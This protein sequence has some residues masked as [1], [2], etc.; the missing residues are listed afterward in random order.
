[1]KFNK[2]NS[3]VTNSIYN[4][5]TSIGG[6]FITV[7]M[8]F[9]VRTVFIHT[10]GRS[11]LGIN[12]LFSNILSMLSLTELGLG[13]A[14]LFKLYDPIAKRDEHRIALLMKFYKTAYRVIGIAVATLGIGLIPFLP[15]LIKNYDSLAALNI[16]AVLIFTLFVF[17][18]V[19]SYLFFSFKS[20]IIK[21]HQKEY[22]INLVSYAFTI[23][24]GILRIIFLLLIPNFFIYILISI[25]QSIGQNIVC[26]IIADRMYPYINEMTAERISNAEVKGIMKDCGALFIYKAN[27]F[28]LKAT[29][30]IVLS[31]FIGVEMVGLYSNYYI[32]YTTINTLLSKIYDSLTHSLGN[33]HT[34]HK[35]HYE[36]EV[37]K[38]I[39]LI[40]AIVGGTIAVGI[41][42]V[43]DEFVN[44]WIGT[45]WVIQQPFSLLLGIELYT[46]AINKYLNRFR[47]I[48]GLFRQAK[49]RPIATMVINLVVSILLAQFC[50]I[51]GVLIGTIV[52]NWLTMLWYDP[53]IIHKYGFGD[54]FPVRNYFLQLVQYTVI[55]AVVGTI[56]YLVC[57]NILVGYGWFSVVIHALLCGI[58]VPI[59]L[60]LTQNAKEEGQYVMALIKRYTKKFV[61]KVKK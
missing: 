30:N 28:V 8:N 7:L 1:M 20:G 14:I 35:T 54:G 12:G 48:M 58:S 10:L 13:S 56:D 4:F 31:A 22:V 59:V 43:A 5:T 49:F 46:L 50:G 2:T 26:A 11:Y 44:T 33:L 39:G 6:Q 3:R 34:E 53:I 18:S 15:V 45:T 21:A 23:A 61:A 47:T 17:R 37:F 60:L 36:Y 38:A 29:D 16:N 52:A 55:I 19:S 41:T 25:V 9:I 51:Y 24:A 57:K 40:T 32:F 42:C 27:S